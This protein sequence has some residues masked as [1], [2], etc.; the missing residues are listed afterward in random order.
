MEGF[1]CPIQTAAQNQPQSPALLSNDGSLTYQQLASYIEDAARRL[2]KQGIKAN[3]TVIIP[4]ASSWQIIVILFA[5]WRLKA[6][7]CL[8]PA[9]L[10][11]TQLQFLKSQFKGDVHFISSSQTDFLTKGLSFQNLTDDLAADLSSQRFDFV[12]DQP[13]TV[14]LTSG[15]TGIPKLVCHTIGNHFWNA[16][17][18]NENILLRMNDG[19]LLSLPLHHVSGLGI[20]FRCFLAGAR[21]FLPDADEKPIDV[22]LRSKE[23]TH[24]SLVSTQFKRLLEDKQATVRLKALKAILLGG[25][26]IPTELVKQ[27]RQYNLALYLTYGLTEAASQVATTVD[28]RQPYQVKPLLHREVKISPSGEIFVRGETLFQGYLQNGRLQRPFDEEGWF[29]TN[30]LGEMDR[31]GNLRIIGRK[32]HM[33]ISGGENI[34]PE[35]IEAA[36]LRQESILEAIIFSQEDEEF[37]LIPIALL[38]FKKGYHISRG[39]L[40]KALQNQLLPFKIPKKFFLLPDENLFTLDKECRKRLWLRWQK[41]Q[42]KYQEIL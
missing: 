34:Y 1:R 35:E 16:K 38:K 42:I 17:G 25:G 23:I 10:P 27:A 19:W 12:F 31:D 32:D 14:I 7:T 6:I 33:F 40:R 5:L 2:S 26:T 18:S 8:I 41:D 3:D 15:T 9:R 30:D 39:E 20:L 22:L 13:A 36:L 37:G 28:P 11:E 4:S 21:I 24:V 29:A